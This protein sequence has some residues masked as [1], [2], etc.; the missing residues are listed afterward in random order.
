MVAAYS[1]FDDEVSWHE[2]V[3]VGAK[4]PKTNE[5]I[6]HQIVNSQSMDK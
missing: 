6:T 5:K 3:A 2:S 4:C 1:V